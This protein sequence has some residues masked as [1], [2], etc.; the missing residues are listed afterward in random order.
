MTLFKRLRIEVRRLLPD[1]QDTVAHFC[2]SELGE[3]AR[4]VKGSLLI[5]CFLSRGVYF[6]FYSLFSALLYVINIILS[7]SSPSF[8]SCHWFVLYGIKDV[9]SFIGSSWS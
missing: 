7:S 3:T 6:Y 9:S 4:P 5:N 8:S 1:F 2:R